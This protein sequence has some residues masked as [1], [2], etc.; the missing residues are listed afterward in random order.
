[1]EADERVKTMTLAQKL[2]RPIMLHR[3]PEETNAERRDAA[4][5]ID[6]LTAALTEIQRVAKT[7][8]IPDRHGRMIGACSVTC[9]D[10]C[11][12]LASAALTTGE[13]TK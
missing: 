9:L 12:T 2:R 4:D 7:N 5:E 13:Q 11:E 6:R 3:N 1:M 10:E 8:E